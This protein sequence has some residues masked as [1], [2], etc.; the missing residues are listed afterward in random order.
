MKADPN[1]KR[2]LAKEIHCLARLEKTSDLEAVNKN[3]LQ[4][5]ELKTSFEKGQNSDSKEPPKSDASSCS[6][7]SSLSSQS[8]R[9]V[10]LTERIPRKRSDNPE[11]GLQVLKQIK[12]KAKKKRPIEVLENAS[13][14]E[15]SPDAYTAQSKA[16]Q[17]KCMLLRDVS[18]EE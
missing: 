5:K 1:S 4:L 3:I 16:E 15:V 8:V 10:D 2:S 12:K 14:K 11:Q 9:M 7:D 17:L 18:Q 6:N 13:L